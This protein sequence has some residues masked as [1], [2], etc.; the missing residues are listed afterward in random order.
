MRKRRNGSHKF[1]QIVRDLWKG[2][3]KNGVVDRPLCIVKIFGFFAEEI[4]IYMLV[5]KMKLKGEVLWRSREKK[6]NLVMKFLSV[7]KRISSGFF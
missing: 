7:Q 2:E 4:Y 1:G 6:I 5:R 3:P